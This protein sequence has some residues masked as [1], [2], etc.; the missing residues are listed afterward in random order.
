[1]KK[2]LTAIT[3]ALGLTCA[4]DA[5]NLTV[6]FSASGNTERLANAI[7]NVVGDD[8]VRIT[9]V[10][11][12]PTDYTERTEYAQKEKNE[13]ARP[14]YQDL[15]VN[16]SDYDT[17]YVGYPIWWYQMP[18]IMYTFFENNDLSG[19]TVVPFNT[20]EGSGNGGTYE[21]IKTLAPNSTVLDGLAV[22]GGDTENDQT[23]TIKT[24][25]QSIGK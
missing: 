22:R 18:M 2:T 6:Y 7:H 8:I 19:K 1:M 21:T 25:L 17:V 16:I 14:Q 5:K 15:G 10:I 9:P 12:Y 23:E 20:H 13:N 3:L 24:W 4:A 11:D